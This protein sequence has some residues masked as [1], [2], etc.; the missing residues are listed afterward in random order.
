MDCK[1]LGGQECVCV[2]VGVVGVVVA[3]AGG[4]QAGTSCV[5]LKGL[6]CKTVDA[7]V[8]SEVNVEVEVENVCS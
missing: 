8:A 1:K 5:R 2:F 6:N 7:D 3:V 4:V